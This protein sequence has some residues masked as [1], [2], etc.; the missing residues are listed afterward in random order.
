MRKD[1]DTISNIVIPWQKSKH[2]QFGMLNE[3]LDHY[4]GKKKKVMSLDLLLC[5]LYLT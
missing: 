1:K 2:P 3:V 4:M 5:N